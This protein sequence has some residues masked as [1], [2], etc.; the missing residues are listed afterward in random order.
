M[1]Q[2]VLS[3]KRDTYHKI[4][5]QS[6]LGRNISPLQL[7]C[8]RPNLEL[9]AQRADVIPD[10]TMITELISHSTVRR[11]WDPGGE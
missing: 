2:Y 4:R 6:S 7:K 10:F 1:E 3:W 11:L 9:K 5:V 8:I